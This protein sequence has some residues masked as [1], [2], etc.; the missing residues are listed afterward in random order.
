ML[1]FYS[2]YKHLYI[3]ISYVTED[4]VRLGVW[5]Y[6][7]KLEYE[8]N[9]L[10]EERKSKLDQLDKTWLEPIKTRS[11]FPEQAILYYIKKVF[12]SAAKL[13]TKAISEID[14]YIPELKI[15][16]EYDGASHLN[17]IKNDIRKSEKCEEMGITLIR[18]REHILPII[19]DKSYKIMLSDDTFSALNNGIIELLNY[20]NIPE[21]T[22]SVN[23]K[24][25]YIEIADNYIKLIDLDWYLMYERLKKYSHKYGNINV[26]IYYKTPDGI[27]LGHWLSNIRSS[28]KNPS[29]G[30][31]R[32]NS[33]KIKLLEELGIDWT[34]I[35]T[36][37]MHNYNL[38]K[39]YYNKNGN[40][41]VP[42]LY[43]TNDKINLGKWIGTQRRTYKAGKLAENKIELLDTIGMVWDVYKYQW[44]E[45]YKL[46]EKYYKEN[47][48]LLV[49][50]SYITN[51]GF[52]L[53]S[54]I[55]RQRNY[56]KRMQL[57]KDKIDLLERI[58]MVWNLKR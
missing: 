47:G 56:Y 24:R 32:L 12:P 28:Y 45:C 51:N 35:E 22:I 49:P 18:F 48:D 20:L 46:A 11:S 16:I 6:D 50:S 3:P 53:G 14:I 55:G 43:M 40:L 29:Y 33:N 21:N 23:V 34:P 38:A 54:W 36:Q 8:R 19:N 5:L 13:N 42:D 37:W 58:G 30:N 10:T 2:K 17:K 31:I 44:G 52:Y 1:E 15:G 4:E 41:L 7:R 27:L 26:P 39:D 9:E 25:D 57:T